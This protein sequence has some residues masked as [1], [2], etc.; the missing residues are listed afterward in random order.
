MDSMTS[1]LFGPSRVSRLLPKSLSF[2]VSPAMA[3]AANARVTAIARHFDVAEDKGITFEEALVQTD[4]LKRSLVLSRPIVKNVVADDSSSWIGNLPLTS[5]SG[6]TTLNQWVDWV[7]PYTG[8]HPY[9]ETRRPPEQG[10]EAREPREDLHVGRLHC[11]S[12][13]LGPSDATA[14]APQLFNIFRTLRS[15]RTKEAFQSVR[16]TQ[17]D[18]EKG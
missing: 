2:P 12:G 1:A 14:S 16:G 15:A 3:S 11:V 7:H 10:E 17:R 8:P 4:H 6:A 5:A 13:Q 9:V 18:T